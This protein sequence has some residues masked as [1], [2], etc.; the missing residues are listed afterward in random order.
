MRRQIRETFL[1]LLR[2][3]RFGPTARQQIAGQIG[4][5]LFARRLLILTGMGVNNNIGQRQ[6]SIWNDIRDRSTLKSDA[7]LFRG[8]G[9]VG[10]RR[11]A[12]LFGTIGDAGSE[13]PEATQAR[14]GYR[15][16]KS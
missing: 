1:Q 5:S 15:D 6:L 13:N 2:G 11:E 8:W 14:E 9:F 4:K 7:I 3:L 10:E 16:P 12:E